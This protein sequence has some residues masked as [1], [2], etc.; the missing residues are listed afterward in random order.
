MDDSG[1]GQRFQD[2]FG[3]EEIKACEMKS[4]ATL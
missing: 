1:I 4:M 3:G 2:R